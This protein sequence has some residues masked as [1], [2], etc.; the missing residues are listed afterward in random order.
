MDSWSTPAT[1]IEQDGS[2]ASSNGGIQ[3][4]GQ[5]ESE[6]VRLRR[7]PRDGQTL[8]LEECRDRKSASRGR[9]NIAKSPSFQKNFCLGPRVARTGG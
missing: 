4:K 5:Q 3:D 1:V 7:A 9:D 6:D 2:I 8:S